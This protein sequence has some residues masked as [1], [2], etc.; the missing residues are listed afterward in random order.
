M[1]YNDCFYS[2][3]TDILSWINDNF[4][5]FIYLP[6]ITKNSVLVYARLTPERK[7]QMNKRYPEMNKEARSPV[8]NVVLIFYFEICN[9]CISNIKILN[10]LIESSS[11][12]IV[13]GKHS[14]FKEWNLSWEYFKYIKWKLSQDLNWLSH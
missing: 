8:S 13:Q 2:Q 5:S 14:S 12:K 4:K 6:S 7:T 3:T 1:L 11:S 9:H 10:F